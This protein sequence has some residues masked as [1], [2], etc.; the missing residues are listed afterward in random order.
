MFFYEKHRFGGEESFEAY[1]LGDRNFPYHFHRSFE[2]ISVAEGGLNLTVDQKTYPMTAGDV[3]LIFPNQLHAFDASE[4]SRITIVIFSPE[5]VSSF[6]GQY[7]GMLPDC[8]VFAY[9]PIYSEELAYSNIYLKKAFLY[10][11]CG[12]LTE[13]TSFTTRDTNPGRLHLLHRLLLY[14]EDHLDSGCSLGGAA[15]ELG[16]DY[17]YISRFFQEKMGMSF[18]NYV[19]QY[20][21]THACHL[22]KNTDDT[23][24][25][26]A[27]KCGYD[28]VRTFNRNFKK[29]MHMTPQE[30]K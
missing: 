21:I 2:M 1:S 23:I 20:R 10:T 9:R 6:Y 8:C 24:I 7:R 17:T 30:Y 3:G 22:L 15:H 14:V 12:L 13:N 28:N 29:V 25:T 18:T 26:V 11:I 19:N 4:N 5:L 16:Y 27:M